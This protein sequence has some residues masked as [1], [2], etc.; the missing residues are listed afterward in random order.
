MAYSK[1]QIFRAILESD[2]PEKAE[3]ASHL[4]AYFPRSLR[5]RFAA[6]LG[7]HPL[8][9]EISA[10]MITNALVDQGGS[11]LAVRLAQQSGAALVQVVTAYL[12]FDRL[13]EAA[14]LRRQ[15]HAFDNRLPAAR[16]YRLLLRIEELLSTFCLWSLER[17]RGVDLEATALAAMREQFGV[18]A[19]SLGAVLAAEEW[20]S[21]QQEAQE[22]EGEGLPPDLARQ[23]A[24]L[25]YLVD[26]L[27]V[28][29]LAEEVD[30]DLS[31]VARSY[32]ELRDYL[33]LRDILSELEQVPVRDRWDRLALQML[34]GGFASALFRLSGAMLRESG[35]N[36][37]AFVAARR[38][39]V[40]AYRAF[41]EGLRGNA[42]ANYHPFA[43]LL[44]ALEG[45]LP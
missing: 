8:A 29:A 45:L 39:K 24:H 22:L 13:L 19:K 26:F 23:M 30:A 3:A 4:A 37:E 12:F 7:G 21:C 17:G 35:G 14:A 10:T 18:F 1:M 2:L 16:Q 44:K 34:K 38:Q 25:P 31:S 11:A 43:V 20:Q 9:R 33:G 5:E 28:A 41:R 32:H 6:H 27:P 36:L 42:P 15:I 40:Q